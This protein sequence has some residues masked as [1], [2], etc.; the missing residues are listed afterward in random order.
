MG[1]QQ[2]SLPSMKDIAYYYVLKEVGA[3]IILTLG[4]SLEDHA[5]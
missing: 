1:A 2:W 3:D 4:G 5:G